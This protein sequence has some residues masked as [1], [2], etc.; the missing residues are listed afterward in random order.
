MAGGPLAPLTVPVA[1]GLGGSIGGVLG[2][3]A[4]LAGDQ[5][6]QDRANREQDALDAR[7]LKEADEQEIELRKIAREQ[8]AMDLLNQF[9]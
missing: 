3:A 5:Y 8:A 1:A 9:L 6:E 4:K 2:G 7:Q